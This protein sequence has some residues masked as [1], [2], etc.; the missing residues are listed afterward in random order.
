M[1]QI[2]ISGML[3][4]QAGK[5][6]QAQ[7]GSSQQVRL[8]RALQAQVGKIH[9]GL[10]GTIGIAK[11]SSAGTQKIGGRTTKAEEKMI[12][13]VNIKIVSQELCEQAP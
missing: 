4:A 9:N 13:M 3:A 11:T 7:V 1:I 8:G 12:K 2:N 10:C 5:I 6:Q